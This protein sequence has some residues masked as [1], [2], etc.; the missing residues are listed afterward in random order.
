MNTGVGQRLNRPI[1]VSALDIEM[2]MLSAI[3]K[4]VCNTGVLAVRIPV[5]G[6]RLKTVPSSSRVAPGLGT[7]TGSPGM[8]PSS[9]QNVVSFA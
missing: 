5:K 6:Q 2:E 1:P 9:L 4:N 8:K 7:N 3:K